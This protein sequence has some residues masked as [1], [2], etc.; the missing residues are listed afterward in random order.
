MQSIVKCIIIASWSS[1]NG[2]AVPLRVFLRKPGCSSEASLLDSHYL[3]AR[4]W[5]R[6]AGPFARVHAR[7]PGVSRNNWIAA[8]VAR[9]D[10]A[11]SGCIANCI[12]WARPHS[13]IEEY[14]R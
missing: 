7:V 3:L 4:G 1:A 2:I 12:D 10:A 11:V 9:I 8:M 5:L 13:E 14:V 6:E